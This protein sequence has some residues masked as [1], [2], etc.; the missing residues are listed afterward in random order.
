MKLPPVSVGTLIVLWWG[1]IRR[2]A[3]GRVFTGYTR[4]RHE[5]R[6]GECQ[7][8]GT[9]CQLGRVCPSLEYDAA[10]VASCKQYNDYR[11]PT[12]RLFPTTESDLKDVQRVRP[13]AVCGYHFADKGSCCRPPTRD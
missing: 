9:C 12:C 7:R 2:A 13:D 6:R 3:L 11:D 8:C 10:G 4:R 5:L 1:K